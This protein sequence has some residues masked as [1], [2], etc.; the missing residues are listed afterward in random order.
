MTVPTFE[1][2]VRI[3]HPSERLSG[4]RATVNAQLTAAIFRSSCFSTQI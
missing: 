1:V 4:M 2:A 3:I